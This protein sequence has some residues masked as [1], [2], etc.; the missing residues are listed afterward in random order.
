MT[1]DFNICFQ[2]ADP[3]MKKRDAVVKSK[4]GFEVLETIAETHFHSYL[5]EILFYLLCDEH[6]DIDAWLSDLK[7]PHPQS[8][9]NKGTPFVAISS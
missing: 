8:H 7:P 3:A 6:I 9:P 2:D 1:I 4:Y 5:S